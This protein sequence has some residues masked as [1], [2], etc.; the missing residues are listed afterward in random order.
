MNHS[1]LRPTGHDFA[2]EA[3]ASVHFPVLERTIFDCRQQTQ[4]S[5]ESIRCRRP[6]LD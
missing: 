3:I 5:Q 4:A 1:P 6:Q 2:E